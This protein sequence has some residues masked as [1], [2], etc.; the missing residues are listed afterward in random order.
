[1]LELINKKD[2]TSNV[3]K[4]FPYIFS[5]KIHY[6]CIFINTWPPHCP[7]SRIEANVCRSR[8]GAYRAP[9]LRLRTLLSQPSGCHCISTAPIPSMSAR[10]APYLRLFILFPVPGKRTTKSQNLTHLDAPDFQAGSTAGVGEGRMHH[11]SG[12]L[13]AVLAAGLNFAGLYGKRRTGVEGAG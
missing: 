5:G 13:L 1:M 6:V 9:S 8:A 7:N 3:Y 12:C 10:S 4:Q 11:A 2:Q